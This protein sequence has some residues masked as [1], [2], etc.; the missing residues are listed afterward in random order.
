MATDTEQ[1]VVLLEARIRDFERN[2]AK[3][4]STAQREFGAIER[5]GRQSAQKM[6]GILGD[7]GNAIKS[8]LGSIGGGFL[9]G[10]LAGLIS[11]Q[12]VRQ[13]GQMVK[14]VADMADE[15]ARIN[16]PVEDFQ[17]LTFAARQSGVEADKLADLMQKFNLELGEAQNK[18]NELSRILAANNIPLTD[19]SGK[20]RDQKALFYDVTNLIRNAKTQQDAAVIGAAAFGKAYADALPF[21]QQG[22]Q[23]IKEGEQAARDSGAVISKELVAKAQE[24]DDRWTAAWDTWRAKGKSAVLEVLG[25]MQG[26]WKSI[27]KLID[28]SSITSDDLRGKG[29]I[30]GLNDQQIKELEWLFPSLKSD[31]ADDARRRAQEQLELQRELAELVQRRAEIEQEIVDAKAIDAAPIVLQEYEDRLSALI[32]QFEKV[33][34]ALEAIKKARMGAFGDEGQ[35]GRITPNQFSPE[36]IVP[37]KLDDAGDNLSGSAKDLQKAAAALENSAN[38]V[39]RPLMAGEFGP[40]D[41]RQ[42]QSFSEAAKRSVLELIAASEGTGTSGYNTS[43]AFGRFLPGGKEQNLTGLTLDQIRQLQSYMLANPANTFN[44]SAIGKYQITRTTLDDLRKQ[45]GLSGDQLYSPELQDKLAMQLYR[46]RGF[47]P[48]EGMKRVG[49]ADRLTAINASTGAINAQKQATDELIASQQRE[50]QSLQLEVRTMGMSTFEAAKMRKEAELLNQAKQA[51]LP[52][53]DQ[54]RASISTLATEYARGQQ[55]IENVR[56]TQEA[57]AKSAEELQRAQQRAAQMAAQFEGSFG[58]AMKSF[59]GDLMRGVDATEALQSALAGLADQLMSM[60]VDNMFSGLFGGGTGGGGKGKA[61]GAGLFSMFGFADGGMVRG[62][63]GPRDDKVPAMLSNGEY[64]INADA[65]SKN[66]RLLEAINTGQVSKSANGG[67]VGRLSLPNAPGSAA[68]VSINMPITLNATGGTP[69]QNRDLAEK[70]GSQIEN[71]VR[72]VVVKEIQEQMRPGNML[73]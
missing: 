61:P 56:L 13:L 31:A 47:Q 14:S 43:L 41:P 24:F 17:A 71:M 19:M 67:I 9:A 12:T 10:G 15:A 7:M 52:I 66:R 1:L 37:K 57:A 16:L 45:L 44:S 70:M 6:Q 68:P 62:P 35:L 38:N 3:A 50:N 20:L 55:A 65:T 5:R 69:E 28:G 8:S 51:G 33:Q 18:G 21:L 46:D 29:I 22:S 72:G 58:G 36:T 73:G 32:V 64:V 26:L 27:D 4:S 2:M 48:W 63:G 60:A 34:L 53:T 54:L 40:L 11:E 39:G 25:E 42:I 23:A 30:P 49:D 59:L